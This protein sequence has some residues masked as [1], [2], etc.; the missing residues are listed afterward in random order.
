MCEVVGILVLDCLFDTSVLA[1]CRPSDNCVNVSVESRKRLSNSEPLSDDTDADAGTRFCSKM[2]A[3]L[4]S[5]SMA[6]S[7]LARVVVAA[8]ERSVAALNKLLA[9]SARPSLK[10][11]P[12]RI[13]WRRGVVV[14]G[15]RR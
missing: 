13:G 6:R 5:W 10:H 1:D 7:T 14:S 3:R 15:V 8:R 11:T 2:L 12:T 4:L 9:R